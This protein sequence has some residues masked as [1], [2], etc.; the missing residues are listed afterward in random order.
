MRKYYD[1]GR[2]QPLLYRKH[3]AH[4]MPRRNAAEVA[5]VWL[6][7]AA[8]SPEL[9]ASRDERRHWCERFAHAC[10]RIVGSLEFRTLFL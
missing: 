8:R 4:G 5:K 9:V 7:L 3:R 10:G 2:F 6:R 1:Y